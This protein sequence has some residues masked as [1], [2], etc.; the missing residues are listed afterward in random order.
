MG[1]VDRTDQLVEYYD[2]CRKSQKWYRKVAFHFIHMRLIDSFSIYNFL[3]KKITSLDFTLQII[4]HLCKSE[5]EEKVREGSI[6]RLS[7]RHFMEKVF[8]K[9]PVDN[10][11]MKRKFSKRC[12]VCYARKIRR[13]TRYQCKTCPE[14]PGL[15]PDTCFE[16]YHTKGNYK[17]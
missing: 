17:K 16:I 12:K 2:I 1:Y 11:I 10:N 8:K 14:K 13:E 3:K 7:G 15:C 4:Q 5:E 6:G 9:E